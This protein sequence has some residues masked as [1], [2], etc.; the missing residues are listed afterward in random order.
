MSFNRLIDWIDAQGEDGNVDL[1]G[2]GS[3]HCSADQRGLHRE[4]WIGN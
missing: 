4:P 1:I 2:T 3:T